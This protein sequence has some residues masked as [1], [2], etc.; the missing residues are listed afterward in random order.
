MT[1]PV[2]LKN[3]DFDLFYSYV[4]SFVPFADIKDDC[5]CLIYLNV[6]LDV[7]FHFTDEARCITIV[8][9]DTFS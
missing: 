8:T 9:L 3:F 7:L 5:S 6:L 2:I 4:F 1:L